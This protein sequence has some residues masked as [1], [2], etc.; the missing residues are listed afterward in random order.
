MANQVVCQ[1]ASHSCSWYTASGP[2]LNAQPARA[3]IATRRIFILG[4]SYHVPL[5]RCAYSSVD[6]YRIPLYDLCIDR[7]IYGELWKRGM[8]EHMSLQTDEDEHGIEMRLPY[9]AKAM[10]SRKDEFTIIPI[11]VGALSE[12]KEQEFGRLFSKYLVDPSN[13]FVVSSDFCHWDQRFCYSYYDESKGEIY[14]S[15]EHLDKMGISIREQLD[16]IS[17]SNYLK[18]YC[19]TI[20]GKHPIGML[21]NAITELQKNG[22]NMSFSFF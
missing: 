5:S 21:L 4:P 3:V 16:P 11:L 12:S 2:Q 8:F 7:K 22:M 20:C 9:T 18:K 13:L 14:R 19:N 10:E 6:V 1:E 17:F 15:I